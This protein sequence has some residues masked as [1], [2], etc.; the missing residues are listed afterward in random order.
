MKTSLIL[1]LSPIHRLNY[2]GFFSSYCILKCVHLNFRVSFQ[3]KIIIEKKS[4]EDVTGDV[5]GVKM[6]MS[7]PVFPVNRLYCCSTAWTPCIAGRSIQHCSLV[8]THWPVKPGLKLLGVTLGRQITEMLVS[9]YLCTHIFPP[10]LSHSTLNSS[11]LSNL[12]QLQCDG[13]TPCE[14]CSCA[15]ESGP[16]K[17]HVFLISED[18]PEDSCVYRMLVRQ[19]VIKHLTW[20]H[21]LCSDALGEVERSWLA[22]SLKWV[23]PKHKP[24]V[25]ND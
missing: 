15:L 19:E 10:W 11:V 4:K 18:L 22:T 12:S 6:M 3:L 16:G 21:A 8:R 13:L 17:S 7:R 9:V 2:K 24:D 5:S 14:I 20:C 23:I 1:L 25:P